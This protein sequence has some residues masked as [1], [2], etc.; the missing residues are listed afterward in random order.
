VDTIHISGRSEARV[1]K[2]CTEVGY[3]KS[4]QKNV[5]S[6]FK[7]SGQGHMTH[8]K[9]WGSNDISRTQKL[10]LSNCAYR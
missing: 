2:F 4:Q 1:V 5:K 3:V 8:F 7:R 9:F 10:E 6:F